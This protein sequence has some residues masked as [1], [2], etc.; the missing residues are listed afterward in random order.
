MAKAQKIAKVHYNKRTDTFE[1]Y[2]KV[3]GEWGF[4]CGAR[5]YQV[6]GDTEANHIHYSFLKEVLNCIK[7][8]YEVIEE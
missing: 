7:L 1:L 3:D 2:I 4:C 8:G 5:C 6:E